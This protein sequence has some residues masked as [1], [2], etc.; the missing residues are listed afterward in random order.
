M[1]A[2]TSLAE[3]AERTCDRLRPHRPTSPHS[4][5]FRAAIAM[6]AGIAIGAIVIAAGARSPVA[7]EAAHPD[8]GRTGPPPT[9][10]LQGAREIADHVAPFYRIS[11]ADQ[12]AVVTVANLASPSTSASSASGSGIG[13]ELVGRAPGRGAAEPQLELGVADQRQHDRL[14]PLRPRQRRLRDRDRQASTRPAAAAPPRGARAGAVHLQVHLGDPERRRDPAAGSRRRRPPP[15][16][17][18]QAAVERPRRRDDDQAAR[19]RAAVPPR[20]ARAAAQPA[21]GSD[22]SEQFPPTVAQV[23]LWKQTGEAGLV[24]QITARGLF[25][26]HISSAQDG[27]S[28]IVLDPL[29]PQ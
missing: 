20:R 29:P 16:A 15:A 10:A 24:A 27:T 28:L 17:S 21:A 3:A 22:A 7:A 5:K 18:R 26:E 19:H 6:L 11:G 13:L 4:P 14:Q 9:A 23:P 2:D 25:S 12:L 8:R 1:T